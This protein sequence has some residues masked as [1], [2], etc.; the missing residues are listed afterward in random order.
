MG[1]FWVPIAPKGGSLLHA[2]SHE[3][4]PLP[5]GSTK[6]YINQIARK[7]GF[8]CG[9]SGNVFAVFEYDVTIDSFGTYLDPNSE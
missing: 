7:K 2:D 4:L 5:P 9:A 8:K 1:Q 6:K 3:L